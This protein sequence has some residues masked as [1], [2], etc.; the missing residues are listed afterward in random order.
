MLLHRWLRWIFTMRTFFCAF[1]ATKGVK[2]I[3]N[4]WNRAKP[5]L[6]RVVQLRRCNWAEYCTKEGHIT[7]RGTTKWFYS[8]T[9]LFL[10]MR[11]QLESTY[12]RSNSWYCHDPLY[13]PDIARPNVTCSV[14][15]HTGWIMSSFTHMPI[16]QNCMICGKPRIMN[17]S[18]AMV[19][20]L[21]QKDRDNSFLAMGSN[22]NDSCVTIFWDEVSFSSRRRE[23]IADLM[24]V[25]FA[26]WDSRTW[27]YCHRFYVG[28][29]LVPKHWYI[30]TAQYWWN[31]IIHFIE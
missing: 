1:G 24:K 22:S 21:S 6:D 20:E 9:T 4:S 14:R 2:S 19:S 12:K 25:C 28:T 29:L 8:I 7:S 13:F 26:E 30:D 16:S 18:T 17:T 31:S 3:Q 15:W 10:I 27:C 5:T 11:N 23:R